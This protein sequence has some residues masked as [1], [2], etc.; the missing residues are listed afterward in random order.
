MKVTKMN[1]LLNFAVKENYVQEGKNRKL[2]FIRFTP[3]NMSIKTESEQLREIEI[4]RNLF[5]NIRSPIT[6]FI[7]DKME[8]MRTQKQFYDRLPQDF[9][10]VK[11]DVISSLESK[12]KNNLAIQRAYYF[13]YEEQ[14]TGDIQNILHMFT[15]SGFSV[16]LVY[17]K[18][19]VMLLRNYYTKEFE[20]TD[21]Y[22]MEQ[23]IKESSK[24]EIKDAVLE[25]EITRRIIPNRMDF[26]VTNIRQNNF[27]RKVLLIKNF[28]DSILPTTLLKAAKVRNTTFTLRYS[29]MSLRETKKLIDKQQTVQKGKAKTTKVTDADDAKRAQKLISEFYREISSRGSAVYMTN[30]YIEIHASTPQELKE[31]QATV[32]GFLDSGVTVEEM[33]Y[34]QKRGFM[35]VQ[36]LGKD[37]CGIIANNL[38]SNTVAALYPC[39]Y[40]SLMHD[41]GMLIG[42]TKDGGTFMPDLNYRDYDITSGN[43]TIIG[44]GGQGKTRLERKFVLFN[45]MFGDTV[46]ILDPEN[47]YEEQVA[48]MGGTVINCARGNYKINPFEVRQVFTDDDEADSEDTLSIEMKN[49]ATFLQHLSWLTD[50]FQ[51]LFPSMG[52]LMIKS[53]MLIVQDTY[54][55]MGIDENTDFKK[56]TVTDYPTFTELYENILEG[57]FE[58]IRTETLQDIR[59]LLRDCYNGTLSIILNGHTNIVNARLINFSMGELLEGSQERLRA[60]LFNVTSYIWNIVLQRRNHV[61]LLLDELYLFLESELMAKYLKSY[62][63]RD[64]KYWA[65]LCISTQQLADCL[66]GTAR[67]YSTAIFD[68]SP[69][70]FNF[71]PGEVDLALAKEAL[72]LKD[73]EFNA[74]ST[75]NQRHCLA[76]IGNG[77]YYVEVGNLPFEDALYGKKSG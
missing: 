3:P 19:L 14:Q 55:K 66:R 71:F 8:D 4:M 27:Y 76:K 41:N 20:I 10:Y 24:K 67:N 42:S 74:I 65:K 50:F 73:G 36:P 30:V 17:R 13:I 25:Q 18:E 48:K 39:S 75:P 11:M 31:L 6:M 52:I 34:E 21:V 2:F 43:S 40:S 59:L 38:P 58:E 35:G 22:M 9:E 1:T 63:K 49:K 46:Y 54:K 51:V 53:I 64:R 72:R 26:R 29:P 44:A 45:Y 16:E 56:L 77:S 12:E 7:T 33:P 47:E 68:N 23:E 70:K 5:D 15:T 37:T 60:V 62:V 28:P 69:F 57:N 32:L 61:F